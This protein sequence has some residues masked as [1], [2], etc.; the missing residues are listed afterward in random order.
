M[1]PARWH[2][3]ADD[4]QCFV[5]VIAKWQMLHEQI[6]RI[7][8]PT[9]QPVLENTIFNTTLNGR[10]VDLKELKSAIG[11]MVNLVKRKN[12]W[13]CVWCV[14]KYHRLLKNM[15]FEAFSRQM[16]HPDWFG[17]AHVPTFT[18]DNLS[19]YK[20]YFTD[21]YFKVWNKKSY[22]YYRSSHDKKKWSN[23]L[24]STFYTLTTRM[25]DA[26]EGL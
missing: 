15:Q 17:K 24:F 13:F 18:G 6:Y 4:L 20:G 23:A 26:F 10:T 19:D 21:N 14:L 12:Q 11:E 22:D 16:M 5:A 8:H 25:N 3:A 1:I 9:V 7:D 2:P